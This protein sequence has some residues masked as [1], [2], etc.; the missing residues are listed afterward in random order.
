MLGSLL[1]GKYSTVVE[2]GERFVV[3]DVWFLLLKE[4]LYDLPIIRRYWKSFKSL[5]GLRKSIKSKP[6]YN[7]LESISKMNFGHMLLSYCKEMPKSFTGYGSPPSLFLGNRS[8]TV[9][10]TLELSQKS[11]TPAPRSTFSSSFTKHIS[12]EVHASS[13]Y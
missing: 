13:H 2:R 5:F 10:G 4:W 6:I 1:T 11:D 12:A 7:L 8:H 9:E 3:L